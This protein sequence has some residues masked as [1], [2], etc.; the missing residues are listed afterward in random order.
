MRHRPIASR[1][2]QNRADVK[3]LWLDPIVVAG[4]WVLAGAVAYSAVRSVTKPFR[5][6]GARTTPQ[7][8]P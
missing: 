5:R 2:G 7:P 3:H 8:T 4:P 6:K 1:F